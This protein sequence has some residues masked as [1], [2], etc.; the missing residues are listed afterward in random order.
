MEFS[1]FF[2]MWGQL[3]AQQQAALCGGAFSRKVGKGEVM[4][5]GDADCTGLLLVQSGQLR[6]FMLSPEGREITLYRLFQRDLCLLSASCMMRSIQF[7]ITIQA[8]KDT[9][10]WVIPAEIYKRVMEAS[11]P[12]ANF[13]NEVMAARFSEV[14]W[15][16]EQ[17]LWKSFDKR[18]AGFLLEECAL[19]K[20][21]SLR[22]THEIIGSHLGTAREVVTRMLRYFQSEGMVRLKRGT[23][24]ITNPVKL[25]SL[26]GP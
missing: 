10:L 19:E 15:L 14:M 12:L 18:L 17:I 2:P 25:K 3:T 5:S 21:S 20:T 4:H 9:T 16:I 13:T 23:V 7:D 6:A 8:E 22:I 11:A 24:E 26:Y 1:A